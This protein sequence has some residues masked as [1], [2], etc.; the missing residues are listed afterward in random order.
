MS[1]RWRKA[2]RD[3][4]GYRVRTILVVASIAVGVFA[5]GTIAGTNAM[6]QRSLAESYAASKPA[7]AT[8]FT[9]TGFDPELVDVVRR[10][11]GVA[12]AEGR[13]SVTMRVQTGPD[14]TREIQLTALPNWAD[15]RI[16]VVEPESGAFPPGRGEVVLER[17]SL[18]LE[19]LA[20]G[21]RLTFQVPGGREEDLTLAGIA[22]EAGAAPAFFFGRM[23]GYVSFDTLADMGWDRRFDEIRIRVDDPDATLAEVQAV[24]DD[25]RTRIERAGAPVL[26]ALVAEPGAHPAAEL[27][28]AVFLLLGAIGFLSLLVSGFLV[29]NTIAAILAQQTRQIGMMKAVGA[30]A[31]QV[32]G[33]YLAIVVGYAVLALLVAVPVGAVGAYLFTTFTAGLVN[34]DVA[35]VLPPAEVLAIELVVGLVVPLM[36]ALVPVWRGVRVTVREAISSA[37]ISDRFGH[38]RFDRLLQQ[39]RGPSRPTLLAIRNTFRRRGRLVLTLLPLVLGGAVFLTVVNLRGALFG[40]LDDTARYFNY[41]VQLDLAEPARA[42]TVVAEAEQVPG[43]VVAEPWR[44]ATTQRIRPDGAESGS[45][46]TFGLPAGAQ[47]VRPV[48]EEGRW[49]DPGDGN[50]LVVTRNFLTDEP[51]LRVGEPVTLRI[52]G[53]DSTWTLVGIVQSPTMRPFAYVPSEAVERITRDAGK[54]GVLMVQTD[55]TDP[56]SQVRIGKAVRERLEAAGVEVSTV[57]TTADI[58]GTLSTLF[59]TLVVFVSVMAVLLGIV[60][61]LGLAGTMTINVVERSREIGVIRAVGASDVAVLLLFLVEGLLIGVVS[62]ALAAILALPLSKVLSDAMGEVFV[63]RPLSFS[64]SIPGLALWLAI[65]LVLATLA[66]ILPSWRASRIAVREVLAYE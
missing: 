50:A 30:R 40:T 21:A 9:A 56:A 6:L 31:D 60:G 17:S 45:L 63:Q 53:R 8:F 27:L 54:A 37:G 52:N 46:V 12:A 33:V 11:P 48:V 43:V 2:I 28:N 66:S 7:A 51:D 39:L 61:G 22:H 29:I 19:D 25:V 13:R 57:T 1:P 20:P 5:I 15:Q 24:A 49:L 23:L 35:G 18:R 41:Q 16:D 55:P 32:A 59:D 3:L 14:T 64:P 44:F 38:A 62:W 47:T 58:V 10:M 36:A 34:L 42:A 65:V 4:V 26:F